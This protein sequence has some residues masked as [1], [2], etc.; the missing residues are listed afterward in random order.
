MFTNKT[1]ER[2]KAI[3]HFIS[4][5]QKNYSEIG[6]Y[7]SHIEDTMGVDIVLTNG[8]IFVPHIAIVDSEFA[9]QKP[10]MITYIRESF[11]PLNPL[12]HTSSKQPFWKKLFT[13]IKLNDKGTRKYVFE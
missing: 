13:M 3:L 5:I 4:R 11:I 12:F 2:Q 6:N 1:S 10:D 7:K 9:F 8:K